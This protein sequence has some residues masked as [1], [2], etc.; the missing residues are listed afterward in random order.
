[1]KA[2]RKQ[3]ALAFAI[4]GLGLIGS[5]LVV[6]A[7]PGSALAQGGG[8]LVP[9]G[10]EVSG[11]SDTLTLSTPCQAC[12]LFSLTQNLINFAVFLTVPLAALMFAIAGFFYLTAGGGERIQ[13]AHKIFQ[14]TLV[15]LI[16]ILAA[17]FIID[18]IM[19]TFTGDALLPW[20]RIECAERTG[21]IDPNA[22]TVP[23]SG[24]SPPPSAPTGGGPVYTH[25][26]AAAILQDANITVVSSTGCI[27]PK[28]TGCT[29]LEGIQQD[30]LDHIVS[31]GQACN[32]AVTVTGGTED[33]HAAGTFSHG[34]G[35][36]I[37]L[38]LTDELN[39]YLME[40]LRRAGKRGSHDRYVDACG[41]EYV[42]EG[43]HWDIA[44]TNGV[45]SV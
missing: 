2:M 45:C 38:R 15:G 35:F 14:N 7:A 37:D 10:N 9:C 8:G 21:P 5:F 30:T 19:K 40:N 1:M 31:V 42:L 6:L 4:V 3:L 36:K 34:N 11:T 12:H 24:G 17:W 22:G 18:T 26:E 32:C 39:T 43:D 13:K 27:G 44:V 41:N 28:N 33:G 29:S 25:E 23:P 16:I 20:N